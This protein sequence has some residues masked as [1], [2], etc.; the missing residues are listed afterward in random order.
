MCMFW[1]NS[2]RYYLNRSQ[3]PLLTLMVELIYDDLLKHGPISMTSIAD[4][5]ASAALDAASEAESQSS[6][7]GD[8]DSGRRSK[9][10]T[11]SS[12]A[13]FLRNKVQ[14]LAATDS[15]APRLSGVDAARAWLEEALPD[16]D[17]EYAWWMQEGKHAVT[18][19]IGNSSFTLNRYFVN[20]TLPRPESFREV[21]LC[22]AFFYCLGSLFITYLP[23]P[24]T[25]CSSMNRMKKQQVKP[26]VKWQRIPC[27]VIY[28]Q[29]QN[30]DGIIH[31]DGLKIRIIYH[32]L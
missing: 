4:K 1:I 24:P 13:A 17:R 8:S 29:V 22:I 32:L 10:A 25:L 28:Q 9:A 6:D 23:P 15:Q 12:F 19:T 11:I 5:H 18:F 31:H 16:L 26:V 30:Q 2:R 20:S 14:S 27:S 3:P 21:H 7:A